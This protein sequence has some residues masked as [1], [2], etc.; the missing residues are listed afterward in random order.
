MVKVR[1]EERGDTEK[2]W[3]VSIDW[4][5]RRLI[6]LTHTKVI[7]HSRIHACGLN[8]ATPPTNM[9]YLTIRNTFTVP[10]HSYCLLGDVINKHGATRLALHPV[11]NE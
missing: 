5:S 11:S 1:I 10:R 9:L 7:N 3:C 6:T 4:H 2:V 8:S